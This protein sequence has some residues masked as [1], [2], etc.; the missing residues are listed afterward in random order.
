MALDIEG[1][2]ERVVRL[3]PDRTLVGI[4]TEPAGR[5]RA[6]DTALVLL[7]SGLIHRVGPSRLY[8]RLARRLAALGMPVLRLDL[9][10][11]GD[12][13]VRADN[14]PLLEAIVQDPR[15]AMN[16]L[17]VAG[18]RRF[19]LFGICSGA[20]AAFKT[21]CADERVAGAILVNPQDFVGDPEWVSHA[22]AQRY[23]SKSLFSPR[24]WLNL[25]TGRIEYR[26]LFTVL[27]RQATRLVRGGGSKVED[28]TRGLKAELDAV[29]ARGAR[30]Q[31][32]FSA[33][34]VSVEQFSM[35]LG[36]DLFD[37]SAPDELAALQLDDT[38][39]LFSRRADQ[40]RLVDGV[41]AWLES[42]RELGTASREGS[43]QTGSPSPARAA[44][45]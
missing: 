22:W 23:W 39:H 3:G 16:D 21:A 8:V 1:V 26:R 44:A 38:D 43:A 11:L 5:A 35:I 33:G 18:Y 41:V 29:L 6:G 31:M 42:G 25:L 4:L 32:I 7:N 37:A 45:S 17:A 2:K 28:T 34:D 19:V 9:S 30:L 20:Y 13:D 10:S 36:R 14:L 12:S 24:A 27:W 15:D 40:D